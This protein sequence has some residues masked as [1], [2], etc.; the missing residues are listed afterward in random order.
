MYLVSIILRTRSGKYRQFSLGNTELDEIFEQINGLVR[1]GLQLIRVDYSE[2][3]VK[4]RSLPVAAFDGEFIS[5]ST[6][7]LQRQWE[8]VLHPK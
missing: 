6:Q 7:Q 8:A 3:G 5:Q 2:D 1:T 4:N